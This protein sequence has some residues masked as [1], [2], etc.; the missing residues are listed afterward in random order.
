MLLQDRIQKLVD[1]AETHPEYAIVGSIAEVTDDYSADPKAIDNNT[2]TLLNAGILKS[3]DY[4]KLMKEAQAADNHTMVRLIGK[5]AGNAA[6][7]EE[8]KNGS[9]S[10]KAKELRTISYMGRENGDNVLRSFD[11]LSEVFRRTADNPAMID[12]WDY[13]TGDT[14]ENF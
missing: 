4:E 7:A 6:E 14:I 10:I 9:N 12:K 11:S 8:R 1:F 5:Y 13:L 3:S 2:L